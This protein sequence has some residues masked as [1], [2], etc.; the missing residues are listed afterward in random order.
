VVVSKLLENKWTIDEPLFY[1]LLD[2]LILPEDQKEV[3]VHR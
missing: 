2:R 1:D 3:I